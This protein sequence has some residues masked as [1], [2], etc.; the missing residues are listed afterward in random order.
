MIRPRAVGRRVDQAATYDDLKA[1]IE[2]KASAKRAERVCA[3]CV[4][5][6][7]GDTWAPIVTKDGMVVTLNRGGFV[8]QMGARA[9][10]R[11][12]GVVRRPNHHCTCNVQPS[13]AQP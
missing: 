3:E 1:A 10:F 8:Q 11:W 4:R 13:E 9:A 6:E 2:S 5:A 7:D 12:V